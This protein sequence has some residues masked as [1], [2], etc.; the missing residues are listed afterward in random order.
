MKQKSNSIHHPTYTFP[1]IWN[2]TDTTLVLDYEKQLETT[3][4]QVPEYMYL[5]KTN[6]VSGLGIG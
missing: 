4:T 6:S 2:F 5:A 3:P 1:E